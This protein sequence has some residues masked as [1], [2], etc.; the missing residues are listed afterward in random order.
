MNRKP[1]FP[2]NFKKP[3]YLGFNLLSIFFNLLDGQQLSHFG[4]AAWITDHSGAIAYDGDWPVPL[5]L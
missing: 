5:F 1:A 2:I 4:F 3:V